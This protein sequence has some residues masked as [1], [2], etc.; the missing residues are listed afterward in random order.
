MIGRSLLVTLQLSFSVFLISCSS[1]SEIKPDDYL[2]RAKELIQ[3]QQYQLAKLYVDSVRIR[4]PKEYAKIREGLSVMREINYAEQNRTLAFCDS[5]L[6][7]RQNELPA[8]K[9]NFTFEK[10]VEYET[11]GHYVYKSQVQENCLGRTFLQTKV[12][13][14]GNLVLTSYYCGNRSL[15]HN[16]VRVS[17][18]DGTYAETNIVPKDGALN[19]SWNDGATHYETVRFNRKAENGVVSF[20]LSH[21]S[22]PVRVSLIGGSAKTYLLGSSDKQAMQAAAELSVILSDITRLLDEMHLAQAKLDYI[23]RKQNKISDSQTDSSR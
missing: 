20:V 7:V 10:N 1:V 17:V 6:E 9:S 2:F 11:I 12:D 8:A 21:T 14:K 13:E 15:N 16:R 5:M 22:Q 18:G 4:F 19:Y 3:K 23:Y